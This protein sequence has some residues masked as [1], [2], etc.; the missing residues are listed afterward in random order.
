MLNRNN[1]GFTLIELMVSAAAMGIVIFYTLSTF[2]VQH[3]TYVVV[4]QVSETQQNSRAIAG[5]IERDL[6]NAGYLVPPP[7]AVCGFDDTNGPDILVISDTDAIRHVDDLPASMQGTD[8][9]V[10]SSTAPANGSTT[11]TVTDLLIDGEASYKKDSGSTS[12]DSDFRVDGGAIVIDIANPQ[13]GVAC[14]KVTAVGT[15]TITVDFDTPALNGSSGTTTPDYR[16]VPAHYYEV[17]TGTD[18]PQLERDG[19]ILAKD[20]EDLQIAWFYD[21]NQDGQATG[22][23]YAGDAASNT[24]DTDQ[25]DGTDLREVRFHVVVATRDNDPRNPNSAGTGQ[26]REN[27]DPNTVSGDDGRRRRVYTATVRIRNN[28]A[29]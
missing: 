1:A 19:I 21:A 3:Q 6:R 7:A 16:V 5:M 24:Y 14:G 28:A 9:D 27:R 8:L 20:V 22:T 2:T 29:L 17:V 15:N 12:L 25:V 13:R 11:L 10:E 18:P 4:D 23:E 26:A